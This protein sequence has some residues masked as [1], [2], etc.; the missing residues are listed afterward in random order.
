MAVE[1]GTQVWVVDPSHSSAEFSVRHMMVS[2]VRGRF[3][4]MEGRILG[5][6]DHPEQSRVSIAIPVT[7]I[8]TGEPQRDAHLRSPD[9]FDAEHHPTIT[10]ESRSIERT[11]TDRFRVVGDLTMRGVT[12]EVSL[13]VTFEGQVRDPFGNQRAGFTAETRI[14]RKD[15]GLH[16]NALLEAG[17]VVVGD[18]VRITVPAEVVLQKAESA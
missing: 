11:G 5:A 9:F 7:S 8:D 16:W 10:F 4:Q 15:W 12:K 17:G 14:N 13:D 6:L 1:T 18:E 3:K 2:H